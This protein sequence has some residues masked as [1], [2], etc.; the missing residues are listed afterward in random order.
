MNASGRAAIR[1]IIT[2]GWDDG[3]VQGSTLGPLFDVCEVM[4]V[5]GFEVPAECE[6]RPSPMLHTVNDLDDNWPAAELIEMLDD[7]S[8][9]SDDLAY[10]ARVLNRCVDLIPA[11]RRY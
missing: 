6:F 10:W 3:D 7:G 4:F 1:S 5:S 9:D 2:M 11:D 8:I